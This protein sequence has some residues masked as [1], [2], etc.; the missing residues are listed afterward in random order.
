MPPSR[1]GADVERPRIPFP[2]GYDVD[3]EGGFARDNPGED[4]DTVPSGRPGRGGR[5]GRGRNIVSR[6]LRG[7]ANLFGGR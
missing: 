7:L 4:F 3:E 6:G 1:S 5:G 2:V